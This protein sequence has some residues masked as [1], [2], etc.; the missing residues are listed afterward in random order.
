M[1]EFSREEPNGRRIV[2]SYFAALQSGD[3]ASVPWAADATLVAPI[4]PGG[5]DRPLVGRDAI[6]EF[7]RP[8]VANLARVEVLN[9]LVDGDWVAGR[10][11]L[12]LSQ[13]AGARLRT[14]NI[15][16]IQRG[17]IVEQENHFDPRPILDGRAGAR[18]AAPGD[19]A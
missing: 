12:T 6:L 1:S 7:L 4:A 13:P 18:D 10:A 9:I 16:R 11:H 17:Q 5:P 14:M 3:L 2:E 8:V 19:R 15:F